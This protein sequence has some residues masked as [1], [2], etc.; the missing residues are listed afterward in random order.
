MMRKFWI[1][2]NERCVQEKLFEL[3]FKWATHGRKYHD[4]SDKGNAVGVNIFEDKLL[5]YPGTSNISYDE[6]LEHYEEFKAKELIYNDLF[7]PKEF[8]E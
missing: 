1:K 4:V 2:G 5:T 8:F 3:G 6:L 7:R